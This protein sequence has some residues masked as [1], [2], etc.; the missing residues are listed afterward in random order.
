MIR[1]PIFLFCLMLAGS[2]LAGPLPA[3]GK[4][5]YL[6]NAEAEKLRDSANMNE[7]ITLFISFAADRIKKLQYEFEHPGQNTRPVERIN[8]LILNYTNCLDDAADL[9]ELAAQKNDDVRKAIMDFQMRLPEFLGYLKMLQG[10]GP[11]MQAYKDNLEDAI[12]STLDAIKSVDEASKQ[13][14]P[15]PV[16]RRPQ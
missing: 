10:Q 16:R 6:S 13:I 11:K 14:A 15:P 1:M 4:K 2:S 5:E 7:R 12:D 8:G 9:V 3:Q